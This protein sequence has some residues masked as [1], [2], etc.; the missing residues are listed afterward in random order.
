MSKS[1]N[2]TKSQL[3]KEHKPVI[4]PMMIGLVAAAAVLMVIGLI[5]LGNQS[6]KSTASI[7]LN[8][9]PTLG[10]ASAPVTMVEYSDY[11]CSHCR[12]FTLDSFDKLKAE[13]IDTGKLKYVVHP[14]YLGN[15][16]MGFIAE[17]AMCAN[18]QGKLFEF[19]H[20]AFENQGQIEV[21]QTTMTDL[22]VS[23]GVDQP[24]FAKCLADRTHQQTVENGR[25]AGINRGINSTPIFFIN[26]QRV[27]GN[28]PYSVF[29]QIIN[30][31]VAIAQ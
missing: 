22:A 15:P 3:N 11:G 26:N 17:A 28:Q 31:E 9:L 1:K 18:E 25:Q 16:E 27:E 6:A 7:D 12:N 10:E 14:Y 13:Y 29:Q 23:V 21:N 24:A 5:I 19:K 30:Q 20:A 4:S 2:Q 8:T